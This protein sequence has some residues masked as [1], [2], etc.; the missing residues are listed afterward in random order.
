VA[1]LSVGAA[2]VGAVRA[3]IRALDHD[4]CARAAR[5]ALAASGPAAVAALAAELLPQAGEA[6]G[7]RADG[8]GGVLALR[9]QP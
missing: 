9:T 7:E 5:E 6:V 2:R 3:W 1:E 8:D 4:A